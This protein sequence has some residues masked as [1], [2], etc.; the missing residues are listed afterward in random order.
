MVDTVSPLTAFS[1]TIET[2][3][4]KADVVNSAPESGAANGVQSSPRESVEVILTQAEKDA[5]ELTYEHL[6]PNRSAQLT[7]EPN[8]AAENTTD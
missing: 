3:S 1:R 7:E 4:I 8:Q 5:E 2:Q 6:R